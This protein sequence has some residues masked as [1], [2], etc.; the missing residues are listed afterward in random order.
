[1]SYENVNLQSNN[2]IIYNNNNYYYYNY[3]YAIFL[4]LY[5]VVHVSKFSAICNRVCGL[6]GC[7][8]LHNTPEKKIC[9]VLARNRVYKYYIHIVT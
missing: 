1:M 9:K 3:Y 6:F 4:I 2:C 5:F 7:L 8:L